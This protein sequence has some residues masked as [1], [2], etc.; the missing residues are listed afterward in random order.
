MCRKEEKK[1]ENPS[2]EEEK[3]KMELKELVEGIKEM[4]EE[5]RC[6]REELKEQMNRMEEAWKEREQK[7][8]RKMGEIEARL[9]EL[10]EKE[11]RRGVRIAVEG[12]EGEETTAWTEIRKMRKEMN[13]RERRERK[14]NIVV[15]G[16]QNK[17][18]RGG[19]E[20]QVRALLEREFKVGETIEKVEKITGAGREMVVVK[21][22]NSEAK[23]KIMSEKK[24]LKERK[25]KI[26]ID[27]DL[28]QEERGIQ[29]IIKERGRKEREEGR[30][31]R[32]GYRKMQINGRKL[33]WNDDTEQL[34]EEK[35]F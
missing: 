21:M 20:G 5:I 6:G 25:E 33:R 28:T 10:E 15:K 23:F 24:K 1:R 30:Q 34:E 3:R 8:E 22:A 17:N 31:V 7:I 29:R 18:E 4:R 26:F 19:I 9:G 14:N 2:L 27:D 35:D 32:I 12:G 11:G 13:R 16:I